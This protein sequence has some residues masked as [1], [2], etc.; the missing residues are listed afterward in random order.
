MH[1]PE[2]DISALVVEK[3]GNGH[4]GTT[5]IYEKRY[6]TVEQVVYADTLHAG[7]LA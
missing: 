3:I 5:H 2:H 1:I 4:G 7:S 6:M